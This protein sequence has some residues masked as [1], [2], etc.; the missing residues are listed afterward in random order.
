MY[1]KSIPKGGYGAAG[2]SRTPA[3]RMPRAPSWSA[4]PAPAPPGPRPA[5]P[6]PSPA[7]SPGGQTDM[8]LIASLMSIVTSCD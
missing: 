1:R 5:V 4:D 2:G 6:S 8:L 7:P 3:R